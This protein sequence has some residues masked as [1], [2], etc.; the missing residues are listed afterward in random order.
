[1][2]WEPGSAIQRFES[3]RLLYAL[4]PLMFA[5]TIFSGDN[6]SFEKHRKEIGVLFDRYCKEKK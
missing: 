6:L 1:M 5:F 2:W 4:L 3:K